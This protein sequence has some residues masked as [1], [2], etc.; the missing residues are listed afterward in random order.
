MGGA[1]LAAAVLLVLAVAPIGAEARWRATDSE[2]L[3]TGGEHGMRSL[4]QI[5]ES[6]CG[7][8]PYMTSFRDKDNNH[9][10]A[11]VL[12]HP[13]WVLTSARCVDPK[14]KANKV[15]VAVVGACNLGEQLTV[16]NEGGQTVEVFLI[17]QTIVHDNWTGS[18]EDGF[19]I[20]L[21]LLK[22]ASQHQYVGMPQGI[23]GLFANDRVAFVGW[24]RDKDH[25]VVPDI[26]VDTDIDVIGNQFCDE[27]SAWPFLKDEMV[28]ITGINTPPD[29]CAGDVGG[30]LVELFAPEG[31]PSNGNP[32]FDVHVA[33]ASFVEE[34]VPCGRDRRPNVY[35]RVAPFRDWIDKK[36]D[37]TPELAPGTRP[38]PRAQSNSTTGAD[39]SNSTASPEGPAEI[40]AFSAEPEGAPSS[41]DECAFCGGGFCFFCENESTPA[42]EPGEGRK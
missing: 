25:K 23:K 11:G 32:K 22:G 8:Y 21:V 14:D 10:C 26:R 9:K 42:P 35:T 24:G 36:V 28:C 13:R 41:D 16:Q 37:A 38:A 30:P 20:A 34:G 29:L 15:N 7:R 31:D 39:A 6:T 2:G 18:F 40:V 5:R 33:I 4:V 17:S 1:A 19:D 3:S 12:I 27:K